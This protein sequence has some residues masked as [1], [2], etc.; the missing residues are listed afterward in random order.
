MNGPFFVRE[1]PGEPPYQ[2][3]AIQALHQR[4]D[5]IDQALRAHG[6]GIVVGWGDSRGAARQDSKRVAMF[7]RVD[8]SARHMD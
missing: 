7:I 1:D 2:G 4:E 8:I 6:V 3:S 5:Q